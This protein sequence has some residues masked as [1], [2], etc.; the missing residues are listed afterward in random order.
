MEDRQSHDPANELE[1]SQMLRVNPRHPIDLK[2]II[3]V[4]GILEEPIRRIEYL[5]GNQKEPFP[6]GKING[7]PQ[8]YTSCHTWRLL[9]SQDHLHPRT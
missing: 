1:V 5:M 2:C 3:V 8:E 4:C 9:R 6:G 7:G